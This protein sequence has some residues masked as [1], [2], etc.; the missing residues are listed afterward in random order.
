MDY[1]GTNWSEGRIRNF[2]ALARANPANPVESPAPS[3]P[4][5]GD[6]CGAYGPDDP[7]PL[8]NVTPCPPVL[9]YPTL[10]TRTEQADTEQLR[11]G[12]EYV[13]IKS[14]VKW[15]VRV[16]YFRDGQFFRAQGGSAP[17]FDGFTLGTGLILGSVLFDVAYVYESGR[18]TS[19]V[20]EVET[21][22]LTP[23]PQGE[24]CS[25]VQ[26]V[27]QQD[28]ASNRIESHKV[29]ASVIYRLPRRR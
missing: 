16:G 25:N 26:V 27:H 12:M 24:E 20:G 10:D 29:Y 4:A 6:F 8:P 19:G 28:P 15:P 22:C 17:R 14:R 23:P 13:V 21:I 18:Y 11:V 7:P 2:F 3:P 1:T 5:S 9:P